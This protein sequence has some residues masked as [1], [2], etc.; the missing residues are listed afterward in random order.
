MCYEQQTDYVTK[1]PKDSQN[2]TSAP[3]KSKVS[4][5]HKQKTGANVCLPH[6]GSPAGHDSEGR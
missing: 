2:G 3:E 4:W 5:R 1:A 6:A